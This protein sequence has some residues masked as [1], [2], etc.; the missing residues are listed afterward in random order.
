MAVGAPLGPQQAPPSPQ[1][2]AAAYLRKANMLPRPGDVYGPAVPNAMSPLHATHPFANASTTRAAQLA[3]KRLG[4]NVGVDG[5]AGPQTMS[6]YNAWGNGVHPGAWAEAYSR[7]HQPGSGRAPHDLPVGGPTGPGPGSTPPP[8]GG[9]TSPGG[10]TAPGKTDPI[11]QQILDTLSHIINPQQYAKA[12]AAEAYDPR[13]N[14]LV[15][16]MAQEKADQTAQQGDI[17][18]WYQALVGQAKDSHDSDRADYKAL[19]GATGADSKGLIDSLGGAASPAA[20][21]AAA[22]AQ[23]GSD[24]LAGLSLADLTGANARKD[25]YAQ[26]GVGQRLLSQKA[27]DSQKLTDFGN[28]ADLRAAKG[29]EYTKDLESAYNLAGTQAKN[30]MNARSI[31]ALAGPQLAAANIANDTARTNLARARVALKIDQQNAGPTG[32]IPDFTKQD[33]TKLSNYLLS[34]ALGPRGNFNQSPVDIYNRMVGMIKTVS[35]GKYDPATDPRVK[36]Y[37]VGLVQSHLSAWNR[38]NPQNRF[39]VKGGKIVHI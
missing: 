17:A 10:G 16:Q 24:Q 5:V 28:L 15:R 2:Q 25:S 32:N 4:Y 34:G 11:T 1:D 6:A 9:G 36:N 30:L 29:N 39:A 22:Q 38:Q 37:L 26:Q 35:Y 14:S 3:L 18:N 13:I 19:L 31:A 12:A 20:A 7:N 23:T 8:A 33:P 27:Y 21:L